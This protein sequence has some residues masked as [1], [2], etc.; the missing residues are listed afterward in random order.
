MGGMMNSFQEPRQD[1]GRAGR[2]AALIAGLPADAADA[3]AMGARQDFQDNT[4][5]ARAQ[6]ENYASMNNGLGG[7][8]ELFMALQGNKRNAQATQLQPGAS[9][10]PP[11]TGPQMPPAQS[12]STPGSAASAGQPANRQ[13]YDAPGT[14]NGEMPLNRFPWQAQQLVGVMTDEQLM[15]MHKALKMGGGPGSGPPQRGGY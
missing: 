6:S 2:K 5:A 7:I 8:M 9:A 11:G 3:I 13:K 1:T 14:V 12:M 15:Q 10:P 4:A